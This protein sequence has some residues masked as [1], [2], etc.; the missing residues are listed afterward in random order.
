[1]DSNFKNWVVLISVLAMFFLEIEAV[2]GQQYLLVQEPVTAGDLT[3]YRHLKNANEYYYVLNQV[4]LATN[5]DG[6]PQFAFTKYVRNQ[7]GDQSEAN[8]TESEHAGAII[9]AILSLSVTDDQK[10]DAAQDLR[11]I[12]PRGKIIGPVSYKSGTVQLIRRTN[13]AGVQ[14][15]LLEDEVIATKHAPLLEGNKAAFSIELDKEESDQL[16]ATFSTPNPD[17]LFTFHMEIEGYSS[18]IEATL[19]ADLEKLY[20]HQLFQAAAVYSVHSA[21]IDVALKNLH[22]SKVIKITQIG[23]DTQVQEALDQFRKMVITRLFELDNSSAAAGPSS[24]RAQASARGASSRQNTARSRTSNSGRQRDQTGATGTAKRRPPSG[25]TASTTVG[26]KGLNPR[27]STGQTSPR[28]TRRR[29]STNQNSSN[30]ASES[31]ALNGSEDL[32]ARATD[33]RSE[34]RIEVESENQK[35][36]QKHKD[37]LTKAKL[38]AEKAKTNRLTVEK[39]LAKAKQELSNLEKDA[40]TKNKQLKEAN[41]KAA[42]VI[43]KRKASE[44]TIRDLGNAI[45]ELQAKTPKDFGA[46]ATANNKLSNERKKLN[47]LKEPSGLKALK[48]AALEA[49]KKV[50]KKKGEIN[51]ASEKVQET[52]DKATKAADKL[53]QISEQKVEKKDKPEFAASLSYRLKRERQKGRFYFEFRKNHAFTQVIS[54][55][56]GIGSINCRPCFQKVNLDD[57]LYKQREVHAY[58]DGLDFADFA[59]YINSVTVLLRKKHQSGETTVKEVLI[60][61]Q[62]FNQDNNDFIMQYGWK[63]DDNRNGWLGYEYKTRWSFHGGYS[64][65][66]DWIKDSFGS[67]PLA[68]PLVKKAIYLEAD[69]KFLESEDVRAVEVKLY[70][71]QGN[72]EKVQ[73]VQI[74]ADDVLSQETNLVLARDSDDYEYQTTWFIRGKDPVSSD[75]I[76]SSNGSLYLDR[77]QGKER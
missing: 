64:I 66:S 48:Q 31:V 71:P 65:E 8:I 42:E 9:T 69:P 26:N 20:M 62:R 63:G 43:K 75:R 40:E 16:W 52:G 22:D 59:E 70:Y 34:E 60:D 39:A 37:E 19:E 32:L 76:P 50:E 27:S 41:V 67:I 23:E 18:P 17:V 53:E 55:D 46:I 4:R 2:R 61:K 1:M 7:E 54:F 49:K 36:E 15:K 33:Q 5:E 73:L 11:R 21:E 28:S 44:A 35:I 45:K 68:P 25:S 6:T 12:D 24:S 58:L 13:R 30:A 72:K 77:L 29:S 56:E 74:K 57:P 10:R 3:L 47:G 14:D 38:E 51:E